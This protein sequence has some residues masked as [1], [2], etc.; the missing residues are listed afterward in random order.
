MARKKTTPPA[1]PLST[2]PPSVT[3]ERFTRLYHLVRLMGT[4][5]VPRD[6]LTEALGLDV[7]GFYRD[8]ELLRSVGIEVVLD[9]HGYGLAES[10]EAAL[11]RLPYPDP[12]LTL[13]EAEQLAKG[14]NRTHRKLAEQIARL[15]S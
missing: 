2:P 6:R 10:A 15:K 12:H 13:G 3:P 4:G 11:A 1:S 5:P 9:Q 7:R 14:R 8:L